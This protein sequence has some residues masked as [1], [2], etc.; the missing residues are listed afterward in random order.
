[1]KETTQQGT[2]YHLSLQDLHTF[3]K[4]RSFEEQIKILT[5]H[6]EKNR[7]YIKWRNQTMETN[8]PKKQNMIKKVINNM[9]ED[10]RA[11]HQVDKA[12]FQ[13]VKAESKA[14][15]EENRFHNSLKRAKE[16]SKKSW[17]DAHM[18]IKERKERINEQRQ[19]AIKEANSR[20]LDAEQ[21]IA[22]AKQK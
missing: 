15:F 5:T 1:M 19:Q 8:K 9:V 22:Q 13:A 20:K 10:A 4:A 7:Q 2:Q 21:R 6:A 17:D 14:T 3:L 16:N 11:Q 12:N 18:S